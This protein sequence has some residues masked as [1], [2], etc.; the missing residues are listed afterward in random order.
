M[1]FR[2]YGRSWELVAYTGK[3]ASVT[4]PDFVDGVRV[5][6]VAARVFQNNHNL[7]TASLTDFITHIGDSAFEGCDNLST[8][9]L[10]N[11][12]RK[13]GRGAFRNC[14]RLNEICYGYI[15]SMPTFNFVP[16]VG[17]LLCEDSL[18]ILITS[19]GKQSFEGCVALKRLDLSY[20]LKEIPEAAFRGCDALEYVSFANDL[21]KIRNEAFAGCDNLGSVRLPADCKLQGAGCFPAS[22][23]LIVEAGSEAEKTAMKH[24]LRTRTISH[25]AID[26]SSVMVP[27]EGY[28]GPHSFFTAEEADLLQERYETRHPPYPVRHRP[29][30]MELEDVP[31]SRFTYREGIY[32][33]ETREPGR[34]RIMMTGDVMARRRQQVAAEQYQDGRFDFGFKFVSKLLRQSDF[35][36]VDLETTASPSAP[37]TSEV[38]RYTDRTH[39]NSP[40]KLLATLRRA[41]VDAVSLAQNH[42]YDSGTLGVLETLEASNRANLLHVGTYASPADSRYLVVDFDGIKVGFVSYMDHERQVMKRANFTEEGKSVLFPYFVREAIREDIRQARDLGAEFIVAY[43]HWGDEHK[44]VISPLQRSFAKM[45]VEEGVNFIAGAHPHRLQHFEILEAPSG[46]SVPCF[47][48]MGNFI[49]DMN[50]LDPHTR[51]SIIA[52]VVLERDENG[53]VGVASTGY[54]PCRIVTMRSGG[55]INHVVVPTFLRMKS[56]TIRK[57]LDSAAKRIPEVIGTE[58]KALSAYPFPGDLTK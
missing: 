55:G 13:I 32:Q 11:S 42:L 3:A 31:L 52:E 41:G 28:K 26:L 38:G 24:G 15:H 21:K 30:E 43:A 56:K 12:L 16:G 54:Y 2:G 6:K 47:W 46:Q 49:S 14:V 17:R 33:G 23:Q 39:L 20:T 48:S 51:D 18:P 29:E 4:V 7:T 37:Y 27:S 10:P 36:M 40:P 44:T 57:R 53:I 25:E 1:H 34:V 45:L 5:T 9:V 58:T 50:N 35:T 22:T 8:L 19:L